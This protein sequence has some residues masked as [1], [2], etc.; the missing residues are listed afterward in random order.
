MKNTIKIT[1]IIVIIMMIGFSFTACNATSNLNGVWESNIQG[2][3]V[4][5]SIVEPNWTLAIPVLG[6]SDSG[7]FTK[8]GNTATLNG[9]R[10]ETWGEATVVNNTTISVTLNSRTDFPGTYTFNKQ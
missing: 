1:G 8:S 10:G 5:L 6:Y 3:V 9:H 4:T 2:A 7:T